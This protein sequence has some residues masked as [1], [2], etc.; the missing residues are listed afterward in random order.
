VNVFQ[1]LLPFLYPLQLVEIAI[2]LAISFLIF[3]RRKSAGFF[4][5]ISL[6]IL[7]IS[8]HTGFPAWYLGKL[9]KQIPPVN[10]KEELERL[11]P[12]VRNGIDVIVVLGAGG[13]FSKTHPVSSQIPHAGVI[14]VAEGARWWR[15]YPQAR[16][17]FS[18]GPALGGSTEAEMM[19]ALA[20]QLGV[21]AGLIDKD[22]HS[23]ST[24]EQVQR[25]S[26]KL[27]GKRFLVITSARKMP[28][29]IKGFQDLKAEAIPVPTDYLNKSAELH[30]NSFSIHAWGEALGYSEI[31]IKEALGMLFR[32]IRP[33]AS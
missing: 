31:A 19:E 16:L 32:M 20:I 23:K 6:L 29:T 12:Q 22:L 5:I 8:S 15:E 14:R 1:Q 21:P 25:I 30:W 17:F 7:F 26:E 2:L 9:E 24:D 18:G 4:L 27:Q 11:Y 33:H 28:R 10:S 13:V 3:N